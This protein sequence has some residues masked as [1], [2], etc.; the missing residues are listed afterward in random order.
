VLELLSLSL[1]DVCAEIGPARISAREEAGEAGG[2]AAIGCH[3]VHFPLRE[4]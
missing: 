3:W 2:F 4:T 1:L